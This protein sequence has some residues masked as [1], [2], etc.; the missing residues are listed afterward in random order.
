MTWD[1]ILVLL[2]VLAALAYIARRYWISFNKNNKGCC[3]GCGCECGGKSPLK[4]HPNC[5][6]IDEL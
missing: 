1:Q 4:E 2:I 3:S 6:S 5:C